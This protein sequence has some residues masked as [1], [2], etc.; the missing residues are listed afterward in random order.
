MITG[1]LTWQ[2]FRALDS[3]RSLNENQ[4]MEHYYKYLVELNEWIIHQ[5]KG[6]VPVTENTGPALSPTS[7]LIN[8]PGGSV[9]FYDTSTDIS[10]MLDVP[11]TSSGFASDIA[12]TQNKLW[13]NT[14]TSIREWDITLN[15]FTAT[16][17][18]TITTPH[19]IGAGLG[20]IDNTT[21]ITTN[22]S[23]T[24]NTVV[25]LDVTNNTVTSTYKFD[26]VVGGVN[27]YIAGD[28]LLTTT[29][30]VITTNH[31]GSGNIYT[32]QFDYA[33]GVVEVDREIGGTIGSPFGLY[34]ENSNIYITNV[35]GN[36]YEIGK[37]SP[38]NMTLVGNTG[39]GI[40]GASQVPSAL[41][42]NFT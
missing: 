29:N 19:S 17:N 36:V 7:V 20:A 24:P 8:T 38:Y 14:S 21:L 31:N 28:L 15:P 11:S 30:K 26:L 37:T 12:H 9:Y 39:V 32:T 13:M 6:T 10:V 35:N 33:T 22:V 27:R 41:T 42:T 34:I 3:I 18:R 23:V 40:F 16:L 1:E 4:Q 2:Q 25:T 5:N